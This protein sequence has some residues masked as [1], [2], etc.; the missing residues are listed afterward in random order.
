MIVL[1]AGKYMNLKMNN[2]AFIHI[3]FLKYYQN[4][5]RIFSPPPFTTG[6]SIPRP[7]MAQPDALEKGCIY[8]IQKSHT[9]EHQILQPCLS[10]EPLTPHTVSHISSVPLFPVVSPFTVSIDYQAPMCHSFVQ[11]ARCKP[12]LAF[13]RL[14][15]VHGCSTM[16]VCFPVVR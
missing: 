1:S 12:C 6:V 10:H 5:Q 13:I 11:K 7:S 16:G 3:K 4:L 9:A 2:K 14:H 8:Q 15:W